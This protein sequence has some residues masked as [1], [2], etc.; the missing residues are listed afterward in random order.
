MQTRFVHHDYDGRFAYR[1]GDWKM[2]LSAHIK[3]MA[4][5]NLKDDVSET[6]NLYKEKPEM[7]EQLT[8]ELNMITQNGRSTAGPIQENDGENTGSNFSGLRN[9]HELETGVAL[10]N[11][12][13]HEKHETGFFKR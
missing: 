9:K 13:I 7:T 12:E 6:K 3:K 2:I 11:D 8:T 10:A 1:S 5:Y 4:L